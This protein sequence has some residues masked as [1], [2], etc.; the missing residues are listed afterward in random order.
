MTI[1]ARNDR[2]LMSGKQDYAGSAWRSEGDSSKSGQLSFQCRRFFGFRSG[3]PRENRV[4]S[5][6]PHPSDFILH[7][8]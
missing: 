3:W 8:L 5:L 2:F 1:L 6:P 7:P 4:L